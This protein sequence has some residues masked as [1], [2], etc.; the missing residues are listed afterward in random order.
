MDLLWRI[1]FICVGVGM[2]IFGFKV[3]SLFKGL[4]DSEKE[5]EMFL[6][7]S[8]AFKIAGVVCLIYLIL[9]IILNL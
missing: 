7:F 8:I 9:E 1:V 6:K 2:I 5:E 3:R 4:Y